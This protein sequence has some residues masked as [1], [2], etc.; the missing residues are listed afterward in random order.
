MPVYV[1]SKRVTEVQRAASGERPDW[2]GSGGTLVTN[3]VAQRA[4]S[5][6]WFEL[7]DTL[8]EEALLFP[9]RYL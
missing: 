4:C 5:E 8:K 6:G 3:A 9:A 7:V 2:K 1:K